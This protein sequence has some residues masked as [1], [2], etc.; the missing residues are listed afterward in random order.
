M[1]KT[2]TRA[3]LHDLVW[4]RPRTTLAKELG[5]S[6]VAIGKHCTRAHVPAPP[7][8]YWARL[9]AGKTQRRESLPIRLP[10]Q[11]DTVEI[12]GD[13]QR[14]YWPAKENLDIPLTAAVFVEDTEQQVSAAMKTIGRV[15]ATRDLKQPDESLSRLQ[16]A[17]ARRRAKYEANPWDLYKPCFDGPVHQR[18]LRIFNSL[19]R[20]LRPLYGRQE[21][22]SEDIW[23]QG[24][25]TLHL[26][27]L[28]LDF[29]A[30]SMGLRFQ[31]P[32][33]HVREKGAKSVA[34][35][36][37]RVGTE[38]GHVGVQEWSDKDGCKLEEQL[39]D[40]MTELLRRAELSLRAQE[41][42]VFEQR[43]E[44]RRELLAQME[45]RRIQEEKK[46]LAAIE[47]RKAKVRDE[48]MEVARRRRVAEDIRAT[49]AALREH[50][51]AGGLKFEAWSAHALEVAES[52]DP[53]NSALDEI[54]GSFHVAR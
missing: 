12:G 53:M 38:D 37:L 1:T 22:C 6:D 32:G 50:P 25:G 33:E 21:V 2:L 24:R 10:G 36:T 16:A 29:G 51:E 39:T 9:S 20:A 19:A 41:V 26:L 15:V 5:V 43:K 45:A 31:E 11:A 7:P 49:V 46:R 27:V 34:A 30:V 35:T 47:A 52:M 17:E 23:V 48:V 42:W 18:Q 54:L 3:E 4:T 13:N 8:G 28:S 44:R 14:R 40:I